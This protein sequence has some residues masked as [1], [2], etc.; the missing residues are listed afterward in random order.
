MNNYD[1]FYRREFAVSIF[2][3]MNGLQ[4]NHNY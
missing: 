2:A 1:F 4:G 3:V